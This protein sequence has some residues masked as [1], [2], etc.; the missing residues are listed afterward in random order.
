MYITITY[1]LGLLSYHRNVLHINTTTVHHKEHIWVGGLFQYCQRQH[2][3]TKTNLN[4]I[5]WPT[6]KEIYRYYYF[7]L[8]TNLQW[9][10]IMNNTHV[11]VY[12]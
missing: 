12:K 1:N 8:K 11:H 5:A 2:M 3:Y 10:K 9:Y 6:R 7:E 4:K